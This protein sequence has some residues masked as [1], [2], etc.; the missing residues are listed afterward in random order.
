MNIS[1]NSSYISSDITNISSGIIIL[2]AGEALSNYKD[3]EI[4]L[5]SNRVAA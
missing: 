4:K 5:H 1:V 3:R 2:Y